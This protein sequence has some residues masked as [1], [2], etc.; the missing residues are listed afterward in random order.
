MTTRQI[1]SKARAAWTRLESAEAAG[2]HALAAKELARW[3]EYE[4]RAAVA[5]GYASEYRRGAKHALGIARAWRE[6]CASV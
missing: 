3:F 2:N 6:G 4:A 1:A 5:R